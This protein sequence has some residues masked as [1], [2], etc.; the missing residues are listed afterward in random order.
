VKLDGQ[1][2]LP[3]PRQQVWD[4]LHDPAAIGRTLPGCSRLER[5]GPG[6]YLA[7]VGV[8]VASITGTYRS[9]IEV[10]DRQAP[11]SATLRVAAAGE[12]GSLRGQVEVHL[13]EVEE[14][15]EVR[16]DLDVEVV[17]TVANV[18]RRLLEGV[19]MRTIAV[20]VAALERELTEEAPEPATVG[21]VAEGD[22][23]QGVVAEGGAAEGALAEPPVVTASRP[24]PDAAS[25]NEGMAEGRPRGRLVAVLVGAVAVVVGILIGRRS[26]R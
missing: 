25:S 10:V 21:V 26:A 23:A 20:F 5:S 14:G 6:R 4:A 2:T 9:D 16:Y 12:P 15:T 11:S 1:H 19:A 22:V 24:V 18:G 8:D 13:D 7:I 3:V 17:G